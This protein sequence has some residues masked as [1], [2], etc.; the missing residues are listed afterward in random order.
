MDYEDAWRYG[1]MDASEKKGFNFLNVRVDSFVFPKGSTPRDICFCMDDIVRFSK[2][3]RR[4][5][6][7][8]SCLGYGRAGVVDKIRG[9]I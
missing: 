5:T 2:T 7:V 8:S 6:F 4:E 1:Q 3:M 9:F